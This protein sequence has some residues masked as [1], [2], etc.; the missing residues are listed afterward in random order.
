VLELSLFYTQ[1][2]VYITHSK[3]VHRMYGQC[4]FQ[5]VCKVTEAKLIELG[6]Y[7]AGEYVNMESLVHTMALVGQPYILA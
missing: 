6:K 4:H 5:G 7:F 3:N 2:A 1:T